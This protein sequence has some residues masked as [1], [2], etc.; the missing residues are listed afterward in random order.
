MPVSPH[1]AC[2]NAGLET[3]EEVSESQRNSPGNYVRR[4]LLEDKNGR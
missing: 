3:N 1:F 2:L 4:G